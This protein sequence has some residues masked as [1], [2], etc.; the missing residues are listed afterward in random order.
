MHLY[1]KYIK[2][3]L[4]LLLLLLIIF[5]CVPSVYATEDSEEKTKTSE[6]KEDDK[7]YEQFIK[8]IENE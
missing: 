2:Q 4:A 5:S 8:E 1:R 3:G 6:E 7:V